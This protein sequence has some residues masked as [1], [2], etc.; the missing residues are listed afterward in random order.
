M[1]EQL[2]TLFWQNN[3]Y[4]KMDQCNLFHLFEMNTIDKKDTRLI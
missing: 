2:S 4:Q 1:R 3:S